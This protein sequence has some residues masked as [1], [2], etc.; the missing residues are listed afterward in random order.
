MK[1]CKISV[2]HKPGATKGGTRSGVRYLVI[3]LGGD[4][5]FGSNFFGGRIFGVVCLLLG[6]E[7][8]VYD[9]VETVRFCP[10]QI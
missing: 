7:R 5:F 9:D 10:L 3:V 8:R 6:V 2:V 1:L 4:I